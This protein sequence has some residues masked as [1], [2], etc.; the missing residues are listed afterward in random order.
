MWLPIQRDC[1]CELQLIHGR[2]VYCYAT[3]PSQAL[4]G[5][6]GG[7][8]GC[9]VRRRHPC[10]YIALGQKQTYIGGKGTSRSL[11]NQPQQH[12]RQSLC[13]VVIII[14]LVCLQEGSLLVYIVTPKS[15][16][17][18]CKIVWKG[19]HQELYHTTSADQIHISNDCGEQADMVTR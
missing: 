17:T 6:C 10:W 1:T 9:T 4:F 5:K 2:Y 16:G 15:R 18:I 3:L 11:Q 12:C 19:R 14:K 8:V 7:K 13:V